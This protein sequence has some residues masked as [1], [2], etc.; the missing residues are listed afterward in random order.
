[1]FFRLF[2]LI[3]FGVWQL[4]AS[5]QLVV[6]VA[7]D[8]NSSEGLLQRYERIKGYYL[9]SGKHLPVN[10]GRN[11]LGWARESTLAS[12]C[13]AIQKREGDGRAPAGIFPL[14]ALFGYAQS[15]PV[16]MPYIPADATRICVDDAA[17]PDYNRIVILDP[18]HPPKSFEWMHRDDAL[19]EFGVVVG[20]NREG[21]PNEGS[22]IFLH[23]E[24][25]ASA[26]TAGCTTM[27]RDILQK[28]M[29]WLDPSKEPLLIQIPKC[30]CS[31]IA[32]R[33]QGVVCP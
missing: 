4:C 9:P 19:Y 11:G 25:N 3:A 15:L 2:F 16:I 13:P 5:E 1:M 7:N 12:Q 6:V 20:Y 29:Q 23:V 24:K 27:P 28:L 8:M 14:T 26:P 30:A 33:Y 22:C 31:E 18:E 10:L 32:S 17:H 21:T